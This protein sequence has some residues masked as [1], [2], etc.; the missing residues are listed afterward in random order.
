MNNN[1]KISIAFLGMGGLL[2]TFEKL[3]AV[4]IWGSQMVPV[5]IN[6][7]GS[8]PTYPNFPNIY[9]N[10]FVLLFTI[11]GLIFFLIGLFSISRENKL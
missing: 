10:I 11:S 5:K 8:Y 7:S 2:Y 9:D 4:L 6:G 3:I 1:I